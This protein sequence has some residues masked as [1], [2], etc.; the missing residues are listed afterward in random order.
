MH[1]PVGS[2]GPP[3]ERQEFR[4]VESAG[5]QL[6]VHDELFENMPDPSMIH[7][8]FG[9]FGICRISLPS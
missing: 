4:R 5:M 3:E 8:H 9:R 2:L 6:W 7:F 1:G